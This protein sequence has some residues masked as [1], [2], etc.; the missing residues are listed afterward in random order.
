MWKLLSLEIKKFRKNAVV[1]LFGMMFLITMPTVIFIGKQFKD[2]PPPFP[3]N[4]TFFSFP[5]IW[6]YLGYSGSWLTF[7]FLGF[8]VLYMITAEVDF[9]TMRQNII[10]GLSRKDFFLSKVYVVFALSLFATLYYGIIALAIG[11]FHAEPFSL[12]GAMANK[13]AI[14]RFFLM[15]LGYTSFALLIGFLIRRSGVAIFFY[16]CYVI[17]IESML[18]AMHLKLIVHKSV[19]YWPLNAMED[20]MPFPPYEQGINVPIKNLDLEF[21]LPMSHATIATIIYIALFIGFSYWNFSRRDI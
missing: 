21:L 4:S 13:M 12:D 9:K 3:S 11:F 10:T 20:L 7:F 18:R 17:F 19:N 15:T 14:P 5:D 8:I 6:R 1:S 16:V 2:L